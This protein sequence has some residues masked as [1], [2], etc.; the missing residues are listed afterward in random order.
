MKLQLIKE[1]IPREQLDIDVAYA[2]FQEKTGQTNPEAFLEDLKNRGEISGTLFCEIHAAE[3]ISVSQFERSA[4]SET[5]NTFNQTGMKHEEIPDDGATLLEGVH[6]IKNQTSTA[7]YTFLGQLGKG[8]MGEV[9]IARDVDLHRKVAFKRMIPKFSKSPK[10]VSRFFSEVQVTSQL[11]H[12]NILPVYGIEVA[13]DGTLGYSM[14]LVQGKALT[15]LIKEAREAH[16]KGEA[17]EEPKELACRLEH[18]LKVCDAISYAHAKGVLHRDLKPDNIMIGRYNQVYLMDW[19]I[20]RVVGSKDPEADQLMG[21]ELEQSAI[22]RT[23]VGAVLG[24]PRYMSPEQAR[25]KNDELDQRS[26]LY[27]LGLILYELASLKHALDGTNLQEVLRKASE[28]QKAPLSHLNP[29]EQ[30]PIEVEAIIHKATQVAPSDRYWDVSSLAEDIRRYLRGEEILARPD[31]GVQ[32]V[33]RFI[34]HHRMETLLAFLFL[35]LV[36]VGASLGILY[37]EHSLLQEQSEHNQRLGRLLSD[38]STQAHKI[39]SYLGHCELLVESLAGRAAA[40][41]SYANGGEAKPYF[42]QDYRDAAS[43]PTDA[44][45]SS[46]FGEDVSFENLVFKIAPAVESASLAPQI[47]RLLLLK[48]PMR[49][50]MLESLPGVESPEALTDEAIKSHFSTIAEKGAPMHRIFIALEEGVIAAYP[51]YDGYPNEYDPR[52]RPYYEIAAHKWGVHWSEPYEDS[53]NK[54]LLLITC[55]TSLYDDQEHFFG[56][57]GAEFT[58]DYIARVLL[59]LP[60]APYEVESF[61]VNAEGRIVIHSLHSGKTTEVSSKISAPLPFE[62]VREA[63]I[64][65]RGEGYL[66]LEEQT[67]TYAPIYQLGWYYVVVA[68]NA[69]LFR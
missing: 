36:G 58:F 57:T 16:K 2:E 31:K 26:D 13:P 40:V 30:I 28:G 63:I 65:K 51:G 34:S 47:Q 69:A 6:K 3:E 18:F 62:P 45:K 17:K 37:Y 1:K 32:R 15:D 23:Q 38:V 61:L 25:G 68:D 66:E 46:Y 11:D 7:R 52:R 22:S 42:D 56:V 20:C 5:L 41:L 19:G 24:T 44:S 43:S 39:D 29:Q 10:L 49:Y 55:A 9:H 27:A 50:S 14:K 59:A 67:I 12:P 54:E 48:N 21:S 4:I 53:T 64:E 8:A 33:L 60:N 35:I